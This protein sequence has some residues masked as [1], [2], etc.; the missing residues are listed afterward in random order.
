MNQFINTYTVDTVKEVKAKCNVFNLSSNYGTQEV[1]FH[2]FVLTDRESFSL[3]HWVV[4]IL[5]IKLLNI[6]IVNMARY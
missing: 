6:K 5:N 1:G 2:L 3:A 4:K